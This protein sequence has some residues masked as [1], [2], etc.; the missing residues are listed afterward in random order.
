ME[1]TRQSGVLDLRIA[2]L[3]ADRD[4]LQLAR[5]AAEQLLAADPQLTWP[6]HA[7]LAAWYQEYSKHHIWGRI[8]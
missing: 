3:A 2:D 1:G 4:L 7:L 6:A 8:S 5:N